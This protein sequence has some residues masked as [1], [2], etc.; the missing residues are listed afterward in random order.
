MLL[1]LLLGGTLGWVVRRAQVQRDVVLAI[2]RA[3]ASAGYEW[4]FKDGVLKKNG[5]PWWPKWLVDR[6]GVDYFGS[7]TV[8][9]NCKTAADA[10]MAHVGRLSQLEPLYL[11]NQPVSDA[12]LAHL[13]GLSKFRGRRRRASLGFGIASA[14][15]NGSF[16]TAS[17]YG[18]NSL[19]GML[20]ISLGCL[21]GIPLILGSGTAWARAAARR[22]AVRPRSPLVAWP[23][24]IAL[25]ALPLTMVFTPWPLR[26]AFLASKAAL[27]QLADRVA[28]GRAPGR[29]VRAG[30]FIV[31]GTIIDPSTGNIGLIIDPDGSGRSGFVR[32]GGRGLD[33]AQSRRIGPFY[34]LNSDLD[35]HD[36]W[37]YQI[38]D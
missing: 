4:E 25:A 19:W 30:L 16:A 10:E 29:P 36:G 22:D 2:Q 8:V 11:F 23:L 12:G 26:A 32:L 13:E 18:F 15:V 31:V 21:C 3:G 24:V 35:L 37:R 33:V 27:D 5:K 7:V 38:E 1:V 17:V 6:F 34:K 20:G 14:M 9:Y 28:D